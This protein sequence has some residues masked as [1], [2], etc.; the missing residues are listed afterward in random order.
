MFDVSAQ[1]FLA[2]LTFFKDFDAGNKKIKNI[3]DISHL[4]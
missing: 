4:F 3:G 1:P 2:L